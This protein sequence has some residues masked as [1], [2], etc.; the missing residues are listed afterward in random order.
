M[1]AIAELSR[2]ER[3]V[4]A[5][6][7]FAQLTGELSLQERVSPAGMSVEYPATRTRV[8]ISRGIPVEFRFRD[9]GQPLPSWFDTTLQGFADLRALPQNW[10]SYGGKPTSYTA[11]N[12]GLRLLDWVMEPSASAPSV[13]P[14]SNGG[15]QLEWHRGGHDLEIIVNPEEEDRYY[16]YDARLDA[17]ESG[18]VSEHRARIEELV[19]QIV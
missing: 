1:P 5:S 4:L 3:G 2:H 12:R 7:S 16:H 6:S 10:D 9:L 13:V 15:L 11:L 14:L 8:F 19:A 18:T 17:E